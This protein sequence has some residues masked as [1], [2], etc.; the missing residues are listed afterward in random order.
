MTSSNKRIILCF[1]N[2]IKLNLQ[3]LRH[4]RQLAYRLH[5]ELVLVHLE[6]DN[7]SEQH[8][9]TT[10]I[11][12][13]KG[14]IFNAYNI[15]YTY[16]KENLSNFTNNFEMYRKS[17]I[18]ILISNQIQ[19]FKTYSGIIDLTLFPT[20]ITFEDELELK[21]LFRNGSN[22]NQKYENTTTL[23][24]TSSNA[25]TINRKSYRNSTST[26]SSKKHQQDRKSFDFK[27]ILKN[28][29]KK[30]EFK[31]YLED[32]STENLN[33]FYFLERYFEYKKLTLP[34]D[35]K[36][37][38]LDI[39]TD[40]FKSDGDHY[41]KELS[42]DLMKKVETSYQIDSASVGLNLVYKE[43]YDTIHDIFKQYLVLSADSDS[44]DGSPPKD[45]ETLINR[46]DAKKL[47]KNFVIQH[48]GKNYIDCFGHLIEYKNKKTV[49]LS[50]KLLQYCLVS[51]EKNIIFHP[52]IRA[53][54]ID[55]NQK[56]RDNWYDLLFKF[57]FDILSNE[58][59]PRFINSKSWKNYLNLNYS[60][61][62]K[63]FEDVYIIKKIVKETESFFETTQILTVQNKLTNETFTGKRVFFVAT[64]NSNEKKFLDFVEHK[65]ILSF[66]EYFTNDSTNQFNKKATTI[67]TTEID[68]SLS[69]LLDEKCEKFTNMEIV[70]YLKQMLWALQEFHKNLLNFKF[71]ELTE[72]NIYL[73]IYNSILV[74]PGIYRKES[75]CDDCIENAPI[76]LIPPEKKI[77]NKSDIFAIGM[78]LFRLLSLWSAEE[79]QRL[80]FVS[81]LISPKSKNS[82]GT[83]D[84][85]LIQK[86]ESKRSSKTPRSRKSTDFLMNSNS[87]QLNSSKR[88]SSFFSLKKKKTFEYFEN[89]KDLFSEYHINNIYEPDILQLIIQMVDPNPE[90]RLNVNELLEKINRLKLNFD[91]NPKQRRGSILEDVHYHWKI[92]IRDDTQRP[93]LK[94][95]LRTEYSVETILFL[96]DCYCYKRLLTEQE[97]FDKADEMCQSYIHEKSTLEVNISAGIKKLFFKNFEE[98]KHS[99]VIN[100]NLFDCIENHIFDTMTVD[101]LPRFEKSLMGLE[102]RTKQ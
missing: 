89:I 34:N 75:T 61:D 14:E 15:N 81:N 48:F 49:E 91:Q 51:S 21:L 77:S 92:L 72:E 95:F 54:I 10:T 13:E 97:R 53:K 29:E 5:Y 101:S 99:G 22:I 30:H 16:E 11:H 42:V 28:E 59:Y 4:L 6:K 32:D 56:F 52:K 12:D 78:I 46:K 50:K 88:I 27:T 1:I 44:H 94:E 37:K 86:E 36:S 43:F 55:T 41:L 33:K 82:S 63:L 58:Y 68:K 19:S 76:Y 39:F 64:K 7:F 80:F 90:S 3:K 98:A 71:G 73:S 62:K 17:G 31:N 67:I 69:S 45:F 26:N 83:P 96:E 87:P 74:D 93:Y 60:I 65:N 47:F 9:I 38:E 20:L 25:A 66:I 40:F 85:E 8:F 23:S 84:N 100:Q 57:V 79:T 2:N 35:I 70:E 24:N 102:S 18:F